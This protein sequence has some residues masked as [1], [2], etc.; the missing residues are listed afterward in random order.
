[1]VGKVNRVSETLATHTTLRL[2]GPARTWTRAADE[3][4]L[5]DAA[6]A[7]GEEV[8]ILGG[9]SNVVAADEGFPGSVIQVATRGIDRDD[10]CLAALLTVQAGEDW[11]GLVACAVAEG[12]AGIECLSGIPG[13]VG[14]APVQN[15]G[16]YGQEVAETLTGVRALDR[17]RDEVVELDA[18]ECG[19]AYRTSRFKRSPGR[20]VVLAVRL[21]LDPDG[22]SRPIRHRALA[23]KLGISIGDTA[24]LAEVRQAVLSLRRGKGM[25]LDPADPDTTSTGSFFMNPILDREEF[26]ALEA[27][28]ALRCGAEVEVPHEWEADGRAKVSAAWLIETAGFPKGHGDPATVAISSKHALALTNRGQGTTAQLISLAQE[29]AAGVRRAFGIS[30]IPEP[31]FIG[32]SWESRG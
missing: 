25:V 13:T 16:A 23:Q 18:T 32:H 14:A 29:I 2:G 9:G 30:L 26:V 20:F 31:I 15:I 24:P 19:F 22:S 21:C 4:A 1:L 27:R 12:L 10:G 7:S 5:V 8:F 28:V 3:V 6:R 11:D 17:A